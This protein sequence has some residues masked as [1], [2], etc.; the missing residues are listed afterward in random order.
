LASK[1]LGLV[2]FFTPAGW[3]IVLTSFKGSGRPPIAKR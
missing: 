2:I 1:A 3:R